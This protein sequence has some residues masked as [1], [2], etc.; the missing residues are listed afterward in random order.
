MN[1]LAFHKQLLQLA[2]IDETLTPS[3]ASARNS[4]LGALEV[5]EKYINLWGPPG[6]GKT[7][8]AHSL[9]H[10]AD[11]VYFSGW[12]RY[13]PKISHYS[14]VAIDNAP[15]TRQEARSLYDEIRWGE[16]GYTGPENVILITREPINDAVH[17][18]TLTLKKPDIA[19]IDNLMR[20]QFSRS[21]F[22]PLSQYAQ[23]RSGLWQYVK[24]LAQIA[25]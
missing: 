12:T 5:R 17:R 19:H 10:R 25:K 20:R 2:E 8:L 3:Q 9:H 13:D 6:V 4:I 21:D 18:I 24:T 22:E 1:W 16:K 7:F 14:V 15:H 11:L 23:Q